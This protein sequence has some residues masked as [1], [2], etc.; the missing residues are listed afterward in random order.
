[1]TVPMAN[2]FK[3]WPEGKEKRSEGNQ[4]SGP[5]SKWRGFARSQGRARRTRALTHTSSAFATPAPAQRT[6]SP[7]SPPAASRA[8]VAVSGRASHRRQGGAE[9]VLRRGFA[10]GNQASTARRIAR[11]CSGV[12][13]QQPPTMATPRSSSSGTRAA[14][15]SGVSS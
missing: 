4:A 13:P 6:R 9:A 11:V 14:I 5:T 8:A 12:V 1:M 3:A 15:V 10:V 7:R 2:A